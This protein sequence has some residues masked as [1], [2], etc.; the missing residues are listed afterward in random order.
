MGG[1][2]TNT[3]DDSDGKNLSIYCVRVQIHSHPNK[4]QKKE[5]NNKNKDTITTTRTL[6]TSTTVSEKS[7]QNK[8]QQQQQQNEQEE[9]K[10]Y[11]RIIPIDD[12]LTTDKCTHLQNLGH[13]NKYEQSTEGPR[14]TKSR[15]SKSS[16]CNWS[17]LDD[18]VVMF[19][20]QRICI[21][22]N[23][24]SETME[25]MQ[26]LQYHEGEYYKEHHDWSDVTPHVLTAYMYLLVKKG[27]G[28]NF[29]ASGNPSMVGPMANGGGSYCGIT[30]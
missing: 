10:H 22:V 27:G 17:C 28:T 12:C 13:I 26:L 14:V 15:T 21:L 6:Q 2:S 25:P 20:T 5:N 23:F 3:K 7:R 24:P 19:I 11:P 30:Y 29:T 18:P 16:W 8:Q 4:K 9:D 1:G